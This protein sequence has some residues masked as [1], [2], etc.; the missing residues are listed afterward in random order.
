MAFNWQES[1][2]YGKACR[3]FSNEVHRSVYAPLSKNLF[4][5]LNKLQFYIYVNFL[6]Y[7]MLFEI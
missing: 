5:E 6:I 3:I 4:K 7:S 2:D 1:K